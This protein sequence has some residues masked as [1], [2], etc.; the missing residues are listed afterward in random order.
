MKKIIIICLYCLSFY[1][2]ASCIS[3]EVDVSGSLAGSVKD[4]S[5][6]QPI[7]NCLVTIKSSNQT[8]RT[9]PAGVYLFEDLD[10]GR[11]TLIFN[12]ITYQSYE[13]SVDVQFGSRTQKDVFLNKMGVPKVMTAPAT[14]ILHNAATINAK[15]IQNGGSEI[16]ELGFY[17]GKEKS[18]MQ[19]V[20]LQEKGFSFQ[21]RLSELE[22]N[23][24]YYYKA[25]AKN[26]F[27]EG[28]GDVLEFTTDELT[29]AKVRTTEATNITGVS[30]RLNAV[31]TSAPMTGVQSMGFYIGTDK[32]NLIWKKH[33]VNIGNL[34][35]YFDYYP[36][37]DSTTYYYQAFVG[38]DDKEVRGDTACFTTLLVSLPSVVTNNVTDVTDSTAI[39]RGTLQSLG[40]DPNTE[41]G[42]VFIDYQKNKETV[43]RPLNE[44]EGMFSYKIE[45]L[46]KNTKY[47][48]KSYAKNVKGITYGST[49]EFQTLNNPEYVDLGLPSGTKWATCNI[50]ADTNTEIGNHYAWGEIT[51]KQNYSMSTYK[52]YNNW[53]ITKYGDLDNK[54]TLDL[55]DDVA[56]KEWGGDWRTPTITDYQELMI[57]CKFQNTTQSGVRGLLVTGPNGNKIFFCTTGYY[58]G[59]YKGNDSFGYYW[60]SSV[61]AR[62]YAHYFSVHPQTGRQSGVSNQPRWFGSCVRAVCK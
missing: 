23:C 17:W 3:T 10:M 32:N 60:T 2:L 1:V 56:Y 55:N 24:T 54:T 44:V 13:D 27:G 7:N 62:T 34:S 41:F 42:F 29:E 16:L 4:G 47:S 40:N 30:A 59:T 48:Y 45:H 25:Y 39:L 38:A 37:N 57:Y 43:I 61:Y 51:T 11:Y 28:I 19:T 58:D 53:N 6:N 31:I 18:D 20:V 8:T 36:L 15:I 35:F 12:A 26:A 46:S 52:Y 14:D 49:H 22:G 5:T 50:G 21:H 33:G 9:N